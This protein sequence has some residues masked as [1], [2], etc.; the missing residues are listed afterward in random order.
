MKNANQNRIKMKQYL[1]ILSG[2]LLAAFVLTSCEG[3]LDVDPEEV[4]PTEEY[5]GD[6]EIE[7]RSALFG[8]L[9]QMQD[10]AGQYIVLGELR[11]DV[12]DVTD[13]AEDELRQINSHNI[14][15]DNSYI[16]PTGLFSII[17][18]CNYALA[19]LDTAAYEN[20]LLE[21]Y[22]SMLRIRTWA[23]MQI[24][25]NYGVLP[26]LT[27]P[28]QSDQ[29]LSKEYPVLTKEQAIDSLINALLPYSEIENVSRYENSLG[30]NIFTMIPDNDI[31]LGD[32]YLW[33]QDFPTAAGYYKHFLDRYVDDVAAKFNLTAT[34]GVT[35]TGTAGNYSVK[36]NNW[37]NIYG[38]AVQANEVTNYVAFSDEYRQSNSAYKTVINQ[39]KPSEALL[40]DW[41]NQ[42][43]Y[44]DGLAFEQ[45]DNRA[46]VATIALGDEQVIVKYPYN[47]VILNRAV[48][49]YLKYAE[50]INYAGYP[51]HA[52][53]IINKGVYD[54]ALT[55][56]AARF[57]GNAASY[58]NF[59]QS[60]YVNVTSSGAFSSGNLGVRGRVGMAPLSMEPI[61]EEQNIDGVDT[62]I[63]IMTLEDSVHQVGMF[64]LEEAG[65][66]TS[67]EGNRWADL[68]RS[69]M[70]NNDASIVADRI[71]AKF[72]A[73]GDL[74]TAE[75][76]KVRLSNPDNWFLPLTIPDNFNK[77][78]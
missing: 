66:E 49:V 18:N 43:K 26:Y 17:N 47:Y 74:A 64:I 65:L 39:L 19:L 50:A 60:K 14:S 11:G 69:A 7:A 56:G 23:Q 10:I 76:L 3:F 13:I 30:F 68:I 24:V 6:D 34:Y 25:I 42:Y 20:R 32:L 53:A 75:E 52:L 1:N 27:K 78:E 8:V 62:L 2:I 37:G 72:E 29:D 54:D 5:L 67:F 36:S 4:L 12:T 28:I 22:V 63:N 73:A 9:A 51:L 38:E 58:L 33:A 21:N 35:Y 40:L 31:L 45:G 71:Y 44:Y 70:E 16:D 15:E 41:S 48:H 46:S 77:V 61:L 55:P 59:T 57:T